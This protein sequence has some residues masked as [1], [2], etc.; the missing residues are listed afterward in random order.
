MPPALQTPSRSQYAPE[1]IRVNNIA[2][3]P[4][5]ASGVG[6]LP[7]TAASKPVTPSDCSTATVTR[8]A[9]SSYA[10][11]P[12]Q[13]RPRALRW[14]RRPYFHSQKRANLGTHIPQRLFFL[15]T[16]PAIFPWSH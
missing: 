3:H 1:I 8:L 4:D 7:P 16:G 13:P 14:R 5:L 6:R 15:Q 9:L 11:E 2:D 12:Q 10:M